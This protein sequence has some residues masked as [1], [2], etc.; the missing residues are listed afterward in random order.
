MGLSKFMMGLDISYY[1]ASKNMKLFTVKL[2]ALLAKKIVLRML[3]LIIM[4]ESKLIHMILFLKKCY[5][6]IELVLGIDVNKTSASKE[7]VIF[8]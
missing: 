7:F 6:M 5:I 3:F 8:Q 2:D 1:L 4:Q